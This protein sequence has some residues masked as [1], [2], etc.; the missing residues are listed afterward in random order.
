[1]AE[2]PE[3]MVICPHCGEKNLP[4]ASRCVHCGKELESFYHIEGDDTAPDNS[5]GQNEDEVQNLSEIL[6]SLQKDAT[7]KVTPEDQP[8][9]P[10]GL[11]NSG[12][13]QP[14][15]VE[16]QGPQV[17]PE[18]LE[19]VRKR[20]KDEEDAKGDLVKGVKAMGESV[21]Q[22]GHSRVEGEFNAWIERIREKSRRDNANQ[23]H[24]L[25]H[26]ASSQGKDDP[27]W[28]KRIRELESGLS[29]EQTQ[30]MTTGEKAPSKPSDEWYR[31]WT[32]EELAALRKAEMEADQAEKTEEIS[33]SS[34]D[35]PNAEPAE[36]PAPS[37]EAA[38]NETILPRGGTEALRLPEEEALPSEDAVNL[39]PEAEPENFHNIASDSG[40]QALSEANEETGEATTSENPEEPAEEPAL[41]AEEILQNEESLSEA[42]VAEGENLSF[43]TEYEP[44]Y[45][46]QYQKQDL[47][48]SE[49]ENKGGANTPDLLLLHSQHDRAE[50]VRS[51]LEEEGRTTRHFKSQRPSQT[52]LS[53]F[54]LALLL[55]LGVIGSTFIRPSAMPTG[56]PSAPVEAFKT[57]LDQLTASSEVLIILD[58]QPAT[59][60]EMEQLAAPVLRMIDQNKIRL[61]LLAQNPSG[62]WLGEQ[63]LDRAALTSQPVVSFIPGGQ[64]GLLALATGGQGGLSPALLP[65]TISPLNAFGAIIVVSDFAENVRGW[66]EQVEPWLSDG[67]LL[68]I[69]TEA[70][71][72][73]LEPYY[74]SGQISGM[75]AGVKDFGAIS[76]TEQETPSYLGYQIGLLLMI[77]LIL[78]GIISKLE[79]DAALQQE[80]DHE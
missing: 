5:S 54:V 76:T 15:K 44:L 12:A 17:V 24:T 35:S 75:L 71:A 21:S 48:E 79:R 41:A 40:E 42:K 23:A 16:D 45:S 4:Q 77:V 66:L 80:K 10:A 46:K 13:G 63:L 26:P 1:M 19:R 70:E 6:N 2:N 32:D 43:E 74:D 11:G 22:E 53:R 31:E 49:P 9:N 28:L 58:Y 3:E 47:S 25:P 72:P 59:S 68:V 60:A 18:W 20:A 34:T 29:D 78:L 33:A 56:T 7:F 61:T 73:M 36:A 55:L 27:D 37:A 8:V 52:W 57:N 69:S 30:E 62:L 51:L 64:L 39:P 67:K 50:Q 14:S 38:Q 65:G